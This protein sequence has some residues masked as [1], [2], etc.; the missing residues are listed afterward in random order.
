MLGGPPDE[1]NTIY[2]S[3]HLK[4]SY[5]DAYVCMHA[6][7]CLIKSNILHFSPHNNKDTHWLSDLS[8]QWCFSLLET[9]FKI[10]HQ[11]LR[12]MM[13]AKKVRGNLDEGCTCLNWTLFYTTL[14]LKGC[15]AFEL[16]GFL[17]LIYKDKREHHRL[18]KLRAGLL[19]H[20]IQISFWLWLWGKLLLG[21]T[22]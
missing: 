14:V 6:R 8:L 19:Q 2:G 7:H 10:K 16:T 5:R 15:E 9:H 18:M 4:C 12:L 21:F 3:K 17:L 20:N 22:I 1:S 13:V 11:Y